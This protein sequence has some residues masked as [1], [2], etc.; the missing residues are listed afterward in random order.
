MC[1]TQE[2]SLGFSVAGLL[3][4]GW[5]YRCG[6]SKYVIA[7]MLYFVL[8]EVL[9]VIQYFFIAY[10]IDPLNPTLEQMQASPACQSTSNKFLTFLGYVHIAFQPCFNT[11]VA[12]HARNAYDKQY[13]VILRLQIL[14]AFLF[15]AR[16]W[17]T[18]VDFA[19]IGMDP[20]YS[21]NP[22]AWE[23]NIEWLN[24]PALC[25][26]KGIYHLAWSVPLAPV[27]YYMCSTGLHFIMM[28]LPDFAIDDGNRMENWFRY[29]RTLCTM[30]TG[31]LLADWIT[32]NK[33]EAASIWCFFSVI[34]VVSFVPYL[35]CFEKVKTKVGK[36][37]S[38]LA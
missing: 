7:A 15:I 37:D 19:A 17:L 5:A 24:G 27:S 1:F 36:M 29:V 9:Q 34:Q 22:E 31:P 3:A 4:V 32:S 25:T 18:W 35:V 28:F 13:Q 10:D 16:Y 30:I 6:I 38:K 2:M 12:G 8:M 20:M 21:F 33:H 14:G 26:Y 11:Y 23:K